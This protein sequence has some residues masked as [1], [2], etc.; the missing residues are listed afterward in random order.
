MIGKAALEK[1]NRSH[2]AVFGLGGVG[3]FAAEAL[4]RGG[5]GTL[6]LIDKDTV[7][8]S[9]I[10]R[11]LYALHSTVGK[12]KTEVAAQRIR[13]INPDCIIHIITGF[14]LPEN[15]EDFHLRD[16]DYI[17]DAID[18]VTAKIDLIVK[19]KEYG[20]PVI[21]CMGT[22]NKL[23]PELLRIADISETSGCPL[24]RVMRRELKKRGITRQTV[25]FSPEIPIKSAQ[26]EIDAESGKNLPAS[27]S[28][29]PPVAGFLMASK[30]IR[31]LISIK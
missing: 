21:S 30:A 8:P 5:V 15:R 24:A 22:G 2:V 25:V 7:S 17:C 31:D 18:N 10:N 20:V 12:E 4:A 16:Y 19:G 28:F 3:S 1:L 14:Y 23:C 11:Q 9:N 13:D 29:T 26:N 27:I 6:T